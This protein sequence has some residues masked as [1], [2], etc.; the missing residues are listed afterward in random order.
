MT[1][2]VCS[3]SEVRLYEGFV[4]TL[5]LSYRPALCGKCWNLSCEMDPVFSALNFIFSSGFHHLQIR[6]VLT[7]IMSESYSL[8]CHNVVSRIRKS[9]TKI[10][11]ETFD[12]SYH[13]ALR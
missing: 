11:S 10:V 5:Y 1:L 2:Q 3:V 9:V 6:E 7:S 12:L 8:F 4:F 13:T